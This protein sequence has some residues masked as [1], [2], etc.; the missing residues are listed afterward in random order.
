M[1]TYS[2]TETDMTEHANNAVDN[3]LNGLVNAKAMTEEQF[4]EYSQYRIALV[5]P[6]MWGRLWKFLAPN[7]NEPDSLCYYLVKLTDTARIKI[8]GNHE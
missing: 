5:R 2:M 3:F 8:E 7:T 4:N 1:K 6:N